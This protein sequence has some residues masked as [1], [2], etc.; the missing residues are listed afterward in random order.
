MNE[1]MLYELEQI[2][3]NS[4]KIVVLLVSSIKDNEISTMQMELDEL[5]IKSN[6]KE[7]VNY[8]TLSFDENNL[9]F[10]YPLTNVLY[11]FAPK[12]LEPLFYKQG[13]TAIFDFFKDFTVARKMINGASFIEATRSNEDI[14]FI[15]KTEEE[16]TEIDDQKLPPTTQ[17]LKNFGKE[18]W[19]SAKRFGYDLP[20][21]VPSEISLKR[22]EECNS[23]EHFTEQ[24]RCTKCG[25]FMKTKVNLAS[26]SCPVGK[27][28]TFNKE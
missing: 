25:C 7:M 12:T 11:W 15:K 20:V 8:Y 9:P 16:F 26:A 2:I 5:I 17:M 3:L 1:Q 10:P 18:M 6:F 21:L 13:Q 28:D 14:Q 27:W 22:Y 19:N 23:C 24:A 4:E